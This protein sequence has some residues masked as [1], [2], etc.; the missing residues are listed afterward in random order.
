MASRSAWGPRIGAALVTGLLAAQVLAAEPVLSVSI[1]PAPVLVG[2]PV[3]LDVL[4]GDISDLF[5]FQFT[6]S[7]DPTVL[8][9]A[10][11]TQG[12]FLSAGG[13]TYFGAGTVDNSAGTIS[14]TF[15][16]LIGAVPGVSGSG[17]LAHVAFDTLGAGTSA[18]TFSDTLFLD[19]ALSDVAVQVQDGTLTVQAV[20]EPSTWLLFGLGLAGVAGLRRRTAA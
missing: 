11:V 4:I 12:S 20:P 17:T 10:A 3:A 1:T 8:Q 7:F 13:T 2:S 14:F 16:T 9:A 19:S 5:A 15:E 6:L 18:L